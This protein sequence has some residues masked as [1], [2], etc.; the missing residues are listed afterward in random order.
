MLKYL[1]LLTF[2]FVFNSLIA[3][4]EKIRT[5][6]VNPYP[7]FENYE[8]FKRFVI[9][10][11][12]TSCSAI[13][14]FNF[15]WGYFYKLKIKENEYKSPMSDG[16]K[17]S[18]S[19]VEVVSKVPIS[20]TFQFRMFLDAHLYYYTEN[21]ILDQENSN[22]AV[23]NDSTFR[24]FDQIDIVVPSQLSSKFK[25]IVDGREKRLGIFYF[26]DNKRIKLVKFI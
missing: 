3:Q 1:C 21:K 10:S 20:D 2:S 14:G 19:L 17:F 4:S 26:I 16:E 13:E 5:I 15:E 6:H 9:N 23:I 18:C 8:H 24:Y 25:S 22:F 12:E 11:Q 7:S